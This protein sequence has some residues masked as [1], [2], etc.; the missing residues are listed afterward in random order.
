[1]DFRPEQLSGQSVRQLDHDLCSTNHELGIVGP[2][3]VE[4]FVEFQEFVHRGILLSHRL[5][6][7][8]GGIRLFVRESE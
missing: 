1:M 4:V 7:S 5:N 8:S 6:H 3:L 2:V